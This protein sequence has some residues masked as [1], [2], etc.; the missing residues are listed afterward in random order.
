LTHFGQRVGVAFQLSDDLLDVVADP[1]QSGKTVGT[2]LREGVP[3]LPVLHARRAAERGSTG[4]PRLI[5]LLDGD[6]SDPARHGEALQ[7][8]RE[9][10]A[11]DSA[12]ADL[13][14]WADEA[15]ALLPPLP[16][17]PAKA[18]LELVCDAVVARTG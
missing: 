1:A 10:P 4:D 8:L 16:D 11:I 7:R 2:D 18:A 14:R 12:R 3:S 15:R 13:R 17:I 9:S 6:L 5:E